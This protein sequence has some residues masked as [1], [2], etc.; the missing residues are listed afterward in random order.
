MKKKAEMM[1]PNVALP[2]L[3]KI[4]RARQSVEEVYECLGE[5]Y[6][7]IAYQMT[8]E[9]F[10]KLVENISPLRMPQGDFTQAK[11]NGPISLASHVTVRLSEVFCWWFSCTMLTLVRFAKVLRKKIV[12]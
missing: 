1:Y 4:R 7:K 10:R 5:L 12:C 6:F 9:S 2:G 3:P 8:Y 11:V